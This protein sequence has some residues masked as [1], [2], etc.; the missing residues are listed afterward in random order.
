LVKIYCFVGIS[1]KNIAE[2]TA[3]VANAKDG[4]K[5]LINE[6]PDKILDFHPEDELHFEKK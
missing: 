6:K 1:K 5:I 2:L 4:D 3:L